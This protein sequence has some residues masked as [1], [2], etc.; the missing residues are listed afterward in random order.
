[1]SHFRHILSQLTFRKA[2][3][4]A[5]VLF[6]KT[7]ALVMA[8]LFAFGPA[9]E[10]FA[11][12]ALSETAPVETSAP[13]EESAP[14]APTPEAPSEATPEVPAEE[15]PAPVEETAPSVSPESNTLVMDIP[16]EEGSEPVPEPSEQIN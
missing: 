12:E 8:M 10:V 2:K 15:V 14:E 16:A 4:A 7:V 1:M 3:K 6:K 5:P 9:V 11:Q 13:A